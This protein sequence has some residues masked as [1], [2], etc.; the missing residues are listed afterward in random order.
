VTDPVAALANIADSAWL[1]GGAVR[2]Q[3]LA[4]AT[5]DFDVAV[6]GP[7]EPLARALGAE[8]G[9]FAFELSEAFGT[10]RVV[11]HDRSW[12]LDLLSL[13]GETIEDDLARRDLTI[14]AIASEL[15]GAGYIDPFGGQEDLRARRLRLV[16][17]DAFARDPLR[18]LRLARLACELDFGVDPE[19]LAAAKR[20]TPALNTV[21]PER[22]FSE[23]RRVVGADRALDGLD[24]ME[25]TGATDAVLPELAALRG[26]E[27]SRFHHLDVFEHTRA[28]LAQTIELEREPDVVCGGAEQ[29]EALRELL[30][31]PLANEMTRGQVLRFGALFHDIAKPETRAVSDQGR[32]TFMG[33]D[34]TGAQ[35]G[36]EILGRL[37]AS[38]RLREYV[39]S[40]TRHHLRLG[41]LVHAMPLSRRAVYDYLRACAPVAPDVTLLSVA[42]RLAT[43]G[44]NSEV[45]IARH[46]ELARQLMGEA[47]AWVADPPRPPV[48]GDELAHALGI[49]PGPMVGGLL[50]ELEAASFSG[51]LVTREQAIEHARRLLDSDG[52]RFAPQ[53]R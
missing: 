45:A 34:E 15:G 5:S 46:L 10:W 14:N 27:Q 21:A 31:T 12:Q 36:S 43:R 3:L 41:F 35:L 40:L 20:S 22:V 48:R 26:V 53:R 37:R 51:E 11:A 42:D 8:A 44:D 18:T 24:L 39:A 32:V 4:R 19:T 30:A 52:E 50:A 47:L 6:A 17:P 16:A 1:V 9:G 13:D 29:C 33:H 25:A 38:E 23:L 7:A 2:D 49:K 28:V